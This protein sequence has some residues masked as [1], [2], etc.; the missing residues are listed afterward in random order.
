MWVVPGWH[1]CI[2]DAQRPCHVTP[3]VREL[4]SSISCRDFESG[5]EV[6]IVLDTGELLARWDPGCSRGTA[7][8]VVGFTVLFS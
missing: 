3:G 4:R 7:P 8:L 6:H 5:I 2:F 1:Q